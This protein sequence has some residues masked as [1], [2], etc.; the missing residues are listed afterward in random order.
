M[1]YAKG[2]KIRCIHTGKMDKPFLL[3]TKKI[4]LGKIYTVLSDVGDQEEFVYITDDLGINTAYHIARFEKFVDY[5]EE[6]G[7]IN[8]RAL[9]PGDRVQIVIERVVQDAAD[10]AG[11][12]KLKNA[13]PGQNIINNWL[14]T[15]KSFDYI[16]R[17]IPPKLKVGDLVKRVDGLGG[18]ARVTSITDGKATVEIDIDVDSLV[19]AGK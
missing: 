15:S 8:L 2:E 10:R 14:F 4:S 18:V 19:K 17:V 13:P 12:V 5:D 6:F 16:G 1:K 11:D 7:P 3:D 9:K